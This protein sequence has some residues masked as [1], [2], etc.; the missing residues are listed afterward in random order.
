MSRKGKNKIGTIILF[1]FANVLFLI[2]AYRSTR[3]QLNSMTL[4]YVVSLIILDAIF[5]F[6]PYILKTSSTMENGKKKP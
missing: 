3:F 4:L 1:V 6:L 5:Y 2:N